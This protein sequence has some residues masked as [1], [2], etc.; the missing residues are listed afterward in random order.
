[1]Q[2]F[3]PTIVRIALHL[4]HDPSG[5]LEQQLKIIHNL[6]KEAGYYIFRTYSDFINEDMCGY[7]EWVTTM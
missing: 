5:A 7:G 4:P 2:G 6:K 1:M 3:K